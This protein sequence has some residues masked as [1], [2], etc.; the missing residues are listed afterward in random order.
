M[1]AAHSGWGRFPRSLLESGAWAALT[2]AERGV[3]GVLIAHADEYGECWPSVERIASGAGVNRRTAQRAI[4]T[5]VYLY[6]LVSISERGG[7]EPGTGRGVANVYVVH[8]IADLGEAIRTPE[9][10]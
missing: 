3:L 6:G 4:H 8:A 9:Y 2:G 7:R 10:R 1:M 5:L